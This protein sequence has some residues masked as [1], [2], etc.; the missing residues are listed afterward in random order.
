[1]GTDVLE[2]PAIRGR[3]VANPGIVPDARTV[4]CFHGAGY[5]QERP[6]H[7]GVRSDSLR[8]AVRVLFC[9]IGW[10][11]RFGPALPFC[12]CSIMHKQAWDL[13]NLR[14]LLTVI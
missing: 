2:E 1:M 5:S 9:L 3:G 7:H 12:S 4:V 6:S 14:R 8:I 11:R 13:Q 10:E